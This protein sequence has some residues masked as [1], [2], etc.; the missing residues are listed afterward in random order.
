LIFS[1]HRLV[2]LTIGHDAVP[3]EDACYPLENVAGW[4]LDK[5]ACNRSWLAENLSW[6]RAD[7]HETNL[8]TQALIRKLQP[9]NRPEITFVVGLQVNKAVLSGRMRCP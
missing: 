9:F 2:N 4:C 3:D 5:Q 1:D 6:N 8:I 7:G